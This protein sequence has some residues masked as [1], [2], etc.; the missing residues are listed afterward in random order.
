LG[1]GRT[2]FRVGAE[3][4]S[5]TIHGVM[6]LTISAIVPAFNR[7][8]FLG[9]ALESAC[10]QTLAVDEIIV[11]DDASNDATPRIA[12]SFSAVQVVR[13][14]ENRGA[15]GARNAGLA[16]ARGD[17]IAWLDS[18]DIWL[19]DHTATLVP[20]LE[21]HP[22]A[23]AAFSGAEFF[24]QRQ[25]R[26]PLPSFPDEE[27]F[28]ALE[29]SFRQTVAPTFAVVTRRQTVLS[30]HGFDESLRASV[31]F[32]LFLRL[33]LCG[34]FVGSHRVTTRYRWHGDQISA[35]PSAQLEAM[36]GSRLTLL[37]SLSHSGRERDALVLSE[38]LLECWHKDLWAASA[39]DDW[40]SLRSLVRIADSL[41]R[42]TVRV[43]PFGHSSLKNLRRYGGWRAKALAHDILSG[44]APRLFGRPRWL[45]KQALDAEVRYHWSRL[46]APPEVW[47]R[48]LIE[49]ANAWGRVKGAP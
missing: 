20:L 32:D 12:S 16:V 24:G 36:Y 11:V 48:H 43:T 23:V 41:R 49:A 3:V 44:D 31:D 1:Y 9:E 42:S 5:A 35:R 6:P 40:T 38:C 47:L 17:V 19:E 15:A 21:Q 2:G 26:W 14:P 13:L 22:G 10:R 30:I 37:E 27:P 33:S 39:I 45:I 25:G 28:D 8:A 4:K 7:E 29:V 46:T 34:T 18:D